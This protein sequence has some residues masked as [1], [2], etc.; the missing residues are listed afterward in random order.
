[1]LSDNFFDGFSETSLRQSEQ[2]FERAVQQN[3][4]E[5][6]D[7]AYYVQLLSKLEEN[8]G[9]KALERD[10]KNAKLSKDKRLELEQEYNQKRAQIEEQ[11][12]KAA[13]IYRKNVYMNASKEMKAQILQQNRD[14]LKSEIKNI[15]EKFAREMS[16]PYGLW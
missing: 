14:T 11:A 1:M 15:E 4:L 8:E 7:K 10:L 5:Y 9:L 16:I 13:S 2:A 3:L 12:A 6:Q